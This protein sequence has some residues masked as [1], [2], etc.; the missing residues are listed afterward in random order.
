M[1]ERK[2]LS[3][4]LSVSLS[5]IPTIASH[6]TRTRDKLFPLEISLEADS[7][8][9][10]KELAAARPLSVPGPL[11]RPL[12]PNGES[13]KGARSRRRFLSQFPRPPPSAPFTERGTRLGSREAIR[14]EGG[15]ERKRLRAQSYIKPQLF[16]HFSHLRYFLGHNWSCTAR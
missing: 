10:E 12:R 2:H 9:T 16:Q 11:S 8:H 6:A 3:L 13:E 15:R 1:I 5:R 7:T 14:R 4:S